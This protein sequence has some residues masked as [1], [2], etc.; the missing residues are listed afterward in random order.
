MGR[1]RTLP[2]PSL[3]THCSGCLR[4]YGFFR[5]RKDL[6]QRY[7]C[8]RCGAYLS[9]HQPHR[10]DTALVGKIIK[11]IIDGIS[12]RQCAR[13]YKVHTNTVQRYVKI[14]NLHEF[15][16]QSGVFPKSR[17]RNRPEYLREYYKKNKWANQ[18]ARNIRNNNLRGELAVLLAGSNKPLKLE[19]LLTAL[20]EKFPD[21]KKCA[22]SYMLNRNA[23]NFFERQGGGWIYHAFPII[24]FLTKK[25]SPFWAFREL[26][27][28][29][30]AI[31]FD[32]LGLRD[33][34]IEEAIQRAVQKQ[35]DFLIQNRVVI[36]LKSQRFFQLTAAGAQI[37]KA[38]AN[39]HSTATAA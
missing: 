5:R 38:L 10:L 1:I 26:W 27:F 30:R 33:E 6:V 31:Y 34:A 21:L 3:C 19:F 2:K 13:T 39:E 7:K 16:D 4:K 35:E 29:A 8:K 32:R 17:P 9:H 18:T 22:L 37:A 20:K 25:S 28:K 12:L 24:P 11:D 23:D 36:A 15:T 14:H